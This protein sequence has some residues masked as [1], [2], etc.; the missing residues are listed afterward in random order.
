MVVSNPLCASEGVVVP[1]IDAPAVAVSL[2][3]GGAA[4]AIIPLTISIVIAATAAA[5]LITTPAC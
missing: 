2:A 4:L 1:A 5:R 3:A